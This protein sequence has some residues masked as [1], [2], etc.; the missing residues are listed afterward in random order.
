MDV[1]T[2]MDCTRGVAA[3]S[4]CPRPAEVRVHLVNTATGQTNRRDTMCPVHAVE[5][6]LLAFR[7]LEYPSR[8]LVTVIVA[9]LLE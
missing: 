6:V 1:P 8:D 7:N 3:G 2:V 4:L 9:P 5:A